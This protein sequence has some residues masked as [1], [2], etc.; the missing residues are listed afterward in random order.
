M[1]L[2]SLSNILGMTL[3]DFLPL[4]ETTD[5]TSSAQLHPSQQACPYP[6]AFLQTRLN[7]LFITMLPVKAKFTAMLKMLSNSENSEHCLECKAMLN[8][9]VE[10]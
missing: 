5:T 6:S 1:I 3:I 9:T 4:Q 8:I 7:M 2:T 10:C